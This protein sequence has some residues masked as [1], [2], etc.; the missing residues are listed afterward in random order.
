MGCSRFHSLQPQ[1]PEKRLC[2]SHTETCVRAC[3]PFTV[4][5]LIDGKVLCVHGGLSPDIRT[6][7][8]VRVCCVAGTQ[9][10]YAAALIFNGLAEQP[11]QHPDKL[12]PAR[13]TEPFNRLFAEPE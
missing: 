11:R 3:L 7:D 13:L 10:W 12:V 5:A 6:L 4:Q 1:Q 9:A 2:Y 8:Q